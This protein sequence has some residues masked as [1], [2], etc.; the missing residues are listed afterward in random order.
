[1]HY[2]RKRIECLI[3]LGFQY[4]LRFSEYGEEGVGD[5]IQDEPDK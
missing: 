3:N 1:M 5:I 2:F 4:D